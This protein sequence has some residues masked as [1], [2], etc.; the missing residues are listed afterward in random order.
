MQT[1]IISAI[2]ET[3]KKRDYRL[4]KLCRENKYYWRIY[5]VDDQGKRTTNYAKGLCAPTQDE[6]RAI[7][8]AKND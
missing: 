2:S 5:G 8:E 3:E 1:Y 7:A 6:A 4:A